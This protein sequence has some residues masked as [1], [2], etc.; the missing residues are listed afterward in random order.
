MI[1]EFKTNMTQS[2]CRKLKESP[3]LTGLYQLLG[4][5]VYNKGKVTF[6]PGGEVLPFK[7]DRSACTF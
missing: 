7:K 1:Q 5:S 2:F 3:F 4:Y 6:I